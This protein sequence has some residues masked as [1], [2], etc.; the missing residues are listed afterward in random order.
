VGKVGNKCGFIP[1]YIEAATG[2]PTL[3]EW[4]LMINC[5]VALMRFG[6]YGDAL[7]SSHEDKFVHRQSTSSPDLTRAVS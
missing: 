2:L 3:F 1:N 7:P 4:I 5:L 6:T